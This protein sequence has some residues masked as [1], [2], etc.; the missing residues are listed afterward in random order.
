M[1]IR[2]KLLAATA[3][4]MAL[5]TPLR[6][7]AA[8]VAEDQAADTAGDLTQNAEEDAGSTEEGTIIVTGRAQKLYRATSSSVGKLPTDPLESSQSVAIITGQLI[9]DQGARDAQDLY[10]NISGVS[11]YS[12]AG[13]A[14]RGFRQE[15]VYYDGLRGD[16]NAG[17]A[18]PQLFNIERV[19][20][21]KGPAGML[22][23]PGAPG[24]LFNYVTKKPSE[25]FEATLRAIAGTA[26][27]FGGLAEINGPLADGFAARG[28]VFYEDKGLLRNNA[29]QQTFIGDSGISYDAGPARIILQATR[30]DLNQ[31]AARLRGVPV[32]DEGNFLTSVRWSANEPDDFLRMKSNVLQGRIEAQPI[33]N[34]I[35]DATLRYN[36]ANEQQHYHELN[37]L[38]D[39]DDDG[40]IDSV[41]REYREQRRDQEIWSFGTN[42]V[43]STEI[44]GTAKNR[45]LVGHDRFAGNESRFASRLRGNN[46]PTAG[47]PSPISILNPVY[48]DSASDSYRAAPI[49]PNLIDSEREGYYFLD[50]ITVGPV[51]VVGGIRFDNFKD[52]INGDV[53]EDDEVTYRFGGVIRPR[54]DISLFA[55]YATSFEPQD[56]AAQIPQAGG[57]FEPSAG[58]IIE[59]GAKAALMNGRVQMSASVY[60]INRTNVLQDDPRGDVG[61]DGIDDSI[62]AGEVVS[63]GFEFDLAADITRN[64]VLT[65][66]YAHNNIRIVDGFLGTGDL[67]DNIGDRLANAPKNTLGFWSRY[68]FPEIGL[69][70]AFGGDYV[71]KRLSP[72]GQTVKPYIIFDASLIYESGP[73]RGLLR[74]DNL[75]NKEYATAGF[76]VHTGH[77]PGRPRTAFLEV[78]YGFR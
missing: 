28:G 2:Y 72:D 16:P 31:D 46:T 75:F 70:A 58:D 27:R 22:Y 25:R 32:D 61:G 41:R 23:G 38:F 12:F 47:L 49:V 73:W 51:I 7:Q 11:F 71:S 35:F 48:G 34:I 33:H 9:E 24:G 6:A 1:N 44:S 37:Q 40:V 57:P 62:A 53:F 3:M 55:Q 18:V 43:W 67:G 60:R 20:F 68:Q 66:N 8:A 76:R 4:M 36:K 30:Y 21:L 59:A 26:S 64:W 69:A 45:V 17:F 74:V 56:P 65:L 13:V 63:K 54:D 39:S 15:E 10:R 29:S 42:A 77:Y 19:E 78:S 14:A 50:E 5:Q 52:D